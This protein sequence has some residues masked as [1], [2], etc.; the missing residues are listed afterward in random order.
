MRRAKRVAHIHVDLE[1]AAGASSLKARLAMLVMRVRSQPRAVSLRSMRGG[2]A[3]GGSGGGGSVP[4]LGTRVE[5]PIGASDASDLEF[6]P[7][8]AM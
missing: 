8:I 5:D 3:V 6:R 4:G 1:M 2:G 7:F